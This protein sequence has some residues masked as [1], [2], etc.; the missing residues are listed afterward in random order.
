M[1]RFF[2]FTTGLLLAGLGACGSPHAPATADHAMGSPR[3]P[4]ACE[5]SASANTGKMGCYFDEAVEL[6]TSAGSAF[7]HVD[8]FP[9]ATSA[10]QA[11]A[12][13]SAVVRA[14]GRI[15]LQTVNDDAGWR[16]AGGRHLATVGPMPTPKGS[17]VTARFMQAMT[18]PGANTRPHRHDGPEAFYLLSGAI[19]METPE[20]GQTT[21]PGETY[22][23]RGGVPMQLTSAGKEVRRSLF[24]VLHSSSQ[25]WMTMA[26]DWTP[27]GA[28]S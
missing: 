25:P 23:V 19:C 28:C 18:Q 10:V 9:D 14:Y 4:G 1:R 3:M 13:G 21:G 5:A 20:G 12:S 7:W 22:W 27:T 24:V 26:P 15:F 2:V 16:P 6:G 11:L 8:E 17:P